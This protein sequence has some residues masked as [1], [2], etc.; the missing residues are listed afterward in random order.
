M[1]VFL[2][3]FILTIVLSVY[4]FDL[5]IV[6]TPLVSLYS[7]DMKTEIGTLDGWTSG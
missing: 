7:S 3:L 4:F 5:R 2:S 1:F 6:I